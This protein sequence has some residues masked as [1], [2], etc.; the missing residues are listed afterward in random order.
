MLM[1]TQNRQN[2]SHGPELTTEVARDGLAR[3]SRV[4]SILVDF[5]TATLKL[6]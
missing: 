6:N 1:P 5:L 4:T 2:R 3:P